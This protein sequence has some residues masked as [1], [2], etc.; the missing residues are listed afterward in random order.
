MWST[1]NSVEFSSTLMDGAAQLKK[2]GLFQYAWLISGLTLVELISKY[3]WRK[4]LQ[5]FGHKF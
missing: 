2:V 5:N 3:S 4:D 1:K